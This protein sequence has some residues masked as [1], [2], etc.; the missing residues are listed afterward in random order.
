MEKLTLSY[1]RTLLN[2]NNEWMS[3]IYKNMDE[4]HDTEWKKP[5]KIVYAIFYKSQKEA[6]LIYKLGVRTVA[7]F[8][9]ELG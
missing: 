4:S 8:E 6:G 2:D 9:V 1:N 7:I 3:A 5:G